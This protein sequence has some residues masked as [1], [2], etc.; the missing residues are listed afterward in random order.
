MEITETATVHNFKDAAKL[1]AELRGRGCRFALDDFGKGVS[2]MAY[3]KN[4]SVDYLKIDG[5]FVSSMADNKIDRAMIA[6]M[7][8]MA[9]ALNIKTI[10]E[11]AES[12]P[13]VDQLASLGVD[14]VQGFAVGRP[15]PLE[16][17]LAEAT[18]VAES[19]V[20]V[21]VA[22]PTLSSAEGHG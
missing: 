14:Y 9:H 8:E 13:V 10:A 21:V 19:R 15:R 6:A 4:M 2:S 20:G 22:H 11:C 7:N 16:T 18:I 12:A 17:L 1:I 5:S 3:L